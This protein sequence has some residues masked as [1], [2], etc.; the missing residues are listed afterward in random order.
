MCAYIP[1]V[2]L[3]CPWR[4]VPGALELKS[5]IIDG[6]ELPLGYWE[7]NPSSPQ[8]QQVLSISE[9]SPSASKIGNIYILR[10]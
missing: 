2:S 1:H 9:P 4:L 5:G 10:L 6:C 3:Q 7:Q 8:E